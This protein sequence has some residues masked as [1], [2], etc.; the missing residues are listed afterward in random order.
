MTRDRV[1]YFA[2]LLAAMLLMAS[3]FVAGKVLLATGI[4]P[5]LLVGWR[6]VLAT[7]A[8]LPLVRLDGPG[9][10]TRLVPPGFGARRWI[11]LAL[12][13]IVQTAGLMGFL[14]LGLRAISPSTTAILIYT[15][16]IWVALLGR[17]ILGERLTAPRIGGFVCGIIGVAYAL[18]FDHIA[19]EPLGGKLLALAGAVCFAAATVAAKRAALPIG[20]WAF[21]FWQMAAGTLVLLGLAAVQGGAWPQFGL[22]DW[23]WFVWLAIGG[24]TGAYGLWFEALR[25]GGATRTSGYLFLAPLFTVLMAAALLGTR[26]AWAQGVGGV[27]TGLGLWLVN[28]PARPIRVESEF[29][30]SRILTND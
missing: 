22:S 10:L 3:S 13:G 21:N 5:F 15:S 9:F 30:R 24:S 26:L 18:G 14:F 8:A 23:G 17:L 28:R 12:I 25:R 6:F 27:L 20:V 16:P 2:A 1:I 19:D 29:S 4:P 7:L 11:V